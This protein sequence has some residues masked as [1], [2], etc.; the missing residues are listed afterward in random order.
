MR[1]IVEV[2]RYLIV[3]ILCLTLAASIIIILLLSL[4]GSP[5]PLV[6]TAP[7]VIGVFSSAVLIIA[8]LG[9][10][11]TLISINDYLAELICEIKL[12]GR[13]TTKG[14]YDLGADELI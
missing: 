8:S 5:I 13:G 11:A 1:L 12:A 6:P 10:T 7:L 2:T 9:I 3:V 4:D 14:V